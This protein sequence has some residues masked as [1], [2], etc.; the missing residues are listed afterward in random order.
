MPNQLNSMSKLRLMSSQQL[1]QCSI[2]RCE[3]HLIEIYTEHLNTIV[4][5][6]VSHPSLW[7]QMINNIKNQLSH[8]DV[9]TLYGK[10]VLTTLQIILC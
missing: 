5:A 8:D 7:R 4:H 9:S 2:H 1:V 3:D 10:I 6:D